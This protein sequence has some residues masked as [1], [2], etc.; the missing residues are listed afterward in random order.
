MS[1]T[2]QATALLLFCLVT[3]EASSIAASDPQVA[4]TWSRVDVRRWFDKWDL[5]RH[6]GKFDNVDG[7]LLLELDEAALQHMGFDQDTASKLS[8]QIMI[9]RSKD[10]NCGLKACAR[11]PNALRRLFVSPFTESIAAQLASFYYFCTLR[12]PSSFYYQLDAG[13]WSTLWVFEIR[14]LFDL[15]FSP[16]C[17]YYRFA[18]WAGVDVFPLW[19]F[20]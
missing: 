3:A 15:K 5:Q 11:C 7:S 10:P 20:W 2:G 14:S 9:L 4:S 17:G 1:P 18:E 12:W 16:S 19:T 13:M 8:R 6:A